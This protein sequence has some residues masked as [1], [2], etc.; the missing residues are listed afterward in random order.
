M[1]DL[2][3][4]S[5][6]QERN[7]CRPRKGKY[8]GKLFTMH[9]LSTRRHWSCSSEKFTTVAKPE[10]F[11]Y[12]SIPCEMDLAQTSIPETNLQKINNVLA[13]NLCY[14]EIL[15]LATQML[16]SNLQKQNET[17]FAYT[18]LLYFEM[19]FIQSELR[20]KP[21]INMVPWFVA[22]AD[23]TIF[24]S[25]GLLLEN[26]PLC[27]QSKLTCTPRYCAFLYQSLCVPPVIY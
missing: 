7:T 4:R 25:R 16:Q 6:D 19:N 1:C 22:I 3:R 11:Y 9:S 2:I 15:Y 24:T 12:T 10:L 20:V 13:I 8:M 14:K 18:K 5:F 23:S 27:W 26:Q 21:M 17:E